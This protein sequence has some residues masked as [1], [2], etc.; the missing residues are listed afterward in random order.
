MAYSKTHYEILQERRTRNNLQETKYHFILFVKRRIKISQ[1]GM[2][3]IT[4]GHF[5]CD[6]C[7]AAYTN[8]M[9]FQ[10]CVIFIN[11][12]FLRCRPRKL[13]FLPVSNIEKACLHDSTIC[14]QNKHS[15]IIPCT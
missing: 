7:N 1:R 5:Y 13:N 4:A 6:L 9:I 8:C 15:Y 3:E 14:E 10:S 2:A 12:R 11:A